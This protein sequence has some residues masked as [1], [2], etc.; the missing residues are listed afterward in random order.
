MTDT[1]ECQDAKLELVKHRAKE[2]ATILLKA[3]TLAVYGGPSGGLTLELFRQDSKTGRYTESYRLHLASED[4]QRLQKE[5]DRLG[6]Y[7]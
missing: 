3:N 2:T 1:V 6:R 5:I 7:P 4:R